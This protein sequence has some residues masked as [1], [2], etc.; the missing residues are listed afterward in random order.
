MSNLKKTS[1]FLIAWIVTTVY[2]QQEG[3]TLRCTGKVA[4]ESEVRPMT[5]ADVHSF[6][7][8]LSKD[9]ERIG[10][11]RDIVSPK[12]LFDLYLNPEINDVR[13]SGVN[14]ETSLMI[15]RIS[16]QFQIT[17]WMKQIKRMVIYGG[18][19]SVQMAPPAR[20]F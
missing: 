17:Y 11:Y 4:P 7:V 12:T 3:L 2:G 1:V 16:G 13:I 10:L 15:D 20:K 8:T 5:S 18:Y 19:C 6:V 9:W 14:P